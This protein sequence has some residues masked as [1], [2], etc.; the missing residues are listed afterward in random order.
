MT[1][2]Q[3]KALA[4]LLDSVFTFALGDIVEAKVA[5]TTTIPPKARWG[6]PALEM[7]WSIIERLL[8]QC[9]AGPQLSYCCVGWLRD[10]RRVKGVEWISECEL[11]LSEPF[12][13]P[14]AESEEA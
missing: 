10:G 6:E 8:R 2:E 4:S 12:A 13:L 5:A 9:E 11:R 7:R 14:A 1:D 3:S